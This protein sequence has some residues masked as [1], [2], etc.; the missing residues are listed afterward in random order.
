MMLNQVELIMNFQLMRN[1]SMKIEAREVFMRRQQTGPWFP[2]NY[3]ADRTKRSAELTLSVV[4]NP[5]RTKNAVK[6][7]ESLIFNSGTVATKNYL[8]NS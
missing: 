8:F 7:F 3:N 5:V 4:T 1:L 2:D 6:Q